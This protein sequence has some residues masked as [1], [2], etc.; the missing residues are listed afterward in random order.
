VVS[1]ARFFHHLL[2]A[3]ILT[4][5]N[6]IVFLL[7]V[8]LL[9]ADCKVPPRQSIT[10]PRNKMSWLGGVARTFV[11]VGHQEVQ[12]DLKWQRAEGHGMPQDLN[13]TTELLQIVGGGRSGVRFMKVGPL[14]EA[15]FQSYG[16]GKPGDYVD[17]LFAC[18][19]A[20]YSKEVKVVATRVRLERRNLFL[21]EVL[22]SNPGD[23][24]IIRLVLGLG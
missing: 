17:L 5:Q 4:L 8:V 15:K 12:I 21:E 7:L 11:R 24:D 3:F 6:F 10:R 9:A 14:V 13:A 2:A 20:Q 23:A 16:R 19:H 18:K 1:I 22:D